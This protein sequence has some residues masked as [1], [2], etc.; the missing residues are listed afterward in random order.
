MHDLDTPI[1]GG[2]ERLHLIRK[3][4]FNNG[5]TLAP[6]RI[7]YVTLGTPQ[8]DL[9]GHIT[10]AIL[11]IHGTASSWQM[12]AEDWWTSQMYGPGQPLDLHSTFVIISDNIG[13]GRSS[14]PSDGLRMGFP[15]YQHSDVVR[16]QHH[17]VTNELGIKQL[18]AVIGSSYGGRLT[19]QWAVQYPHV[20][21]GIIPMIAS[22]FALAGRRGM[23]DY[24]GIEPL[25]I[26]PTWDGGNYKEPPR[27]FPLAIMAYWIFM[28]GVNH[29][30]NAAPTRERSLR[31]LP[32]LAEKIAAKI[33]AND[34][35]YQLRANDEFNV[36]PKLEEI[37]ARVLAIAVDGD[38]MVPVE[39]GQLEEAKRRLGDKMEI[40][41]ARDSGRGHA[42]LQ[43]EI[44]ACAA[45][46]NQFLKSLD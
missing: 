44:G 31:H 15:A 22:P 46:I 25:L 20:V 43:H 40:L 18:R 19:W 39:L 17:L 6:A 23:Q 35:I 45:Q 37:Q 5:Q 10:N 13:A 26:D 4:E 3:I 27:N 21:K 33:D 24:L 36:S 11:L 29:L 30:W 41:L 7:N 38:E 28:S 16:A 34:W 8:H 42:A 9:D 1:G 14:K 12:Y 2:S 32:R